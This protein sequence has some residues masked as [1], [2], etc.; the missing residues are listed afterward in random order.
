MSFEY[1]VS[2]KAIDVESIAFIVKG[3]IKFPFGNF[4]VLFILG[5][6]LV[7]FY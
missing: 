4:M 7:H 3:T 6:F 1:N 5:K 2:A